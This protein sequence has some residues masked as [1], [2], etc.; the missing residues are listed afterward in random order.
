MAGIDG[1]IG[2]NGAADMITPDIVL[3][4]IDALVGHNL[5]MGS[6]RVV[7]L[8]KRFHRRL[9]VDVKYL[10]HMHSDVAILDRP[11]LEVLRENAHVL[12]Q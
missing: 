8:N 12:F 6:D 3:G 2:G 10:F 7:G 11:A 9:P 1:G 4:I 5:G